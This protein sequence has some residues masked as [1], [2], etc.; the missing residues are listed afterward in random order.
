MRV[1]P[2]AAVTTD[3]TSTKL[4]I[5]A[6]AILDRK[7]LCSTTVPW[8]EEMKETGGPSFVGISRD[9]ST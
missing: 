3:H 7:T 8:L 9:G 1:P 4:L 5:K 2:A 6:R